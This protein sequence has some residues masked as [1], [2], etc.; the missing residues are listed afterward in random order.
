M[1]LWQSS[2][3]HVQSDI[4]VIALGSVDAADFVV[5]TI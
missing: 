5:C 1:D 3:L 4:A 2:V